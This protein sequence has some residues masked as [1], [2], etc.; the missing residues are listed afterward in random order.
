MLLFLMN[1]IYIFLK[2]E[3]LWASLLATPQQ[4]GTADLTPPEADQMASRIGNY[5]G[6]PSSLYLRQPRQSLNL[7]IRSYDKQAADDFRHDI[8]IFP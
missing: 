5:S 8:Q 2:F 4:V 7:G 6:T 3:T 1:S